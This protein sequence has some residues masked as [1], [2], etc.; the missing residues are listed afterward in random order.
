MSFYLDSGVINSVYFRFQTEVSV[1]CLLRDADVALRID[2]DTMDNRNDRAL[3]RRRLFPSES[4][5]LLHSAHV[6]ANSTASS[7]LTRS[8]TASNDS[9]GEIWLDEYRH[10]S[11]ESATV[12]IDSEVVDDSVS[13]SRVT[14]SE[15]A[16]PERPTSSPI[17]LN[18]RRAFSANS[19]ENLHVCFVQVPH[20]GRKGRKMRYYSPEDTLEYVVSWPFEQQYRSSK[21]Q[22]GAVRISHWHESHDQRRG[23]T[24]SHCEQI[25]EE[26]GYTAHA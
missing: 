5:V 18:E 1:T 10:T 21:R 17:A 25:V 8:R 24:C 22:R 7:F 15:T 3:R 23:M 11:S 16:G 12:D 2:S 6:S 19:E 13:W 20:T 26:A 9:D 14:R 4:T